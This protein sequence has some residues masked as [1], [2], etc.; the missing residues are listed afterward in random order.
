MSQLTALAAESPA[1]ETGPEGRR[2]TRHTCDITAEY[3]VLG[4]QPPRPR[5]GCL[6]NLSTTGLALIVG[7]P[8]KRR[9]RLGV[10]VQSPDYQFSY[11]LV[12]QV[13]RTLPYHD[14]WLLGC[15]FDRPLSNN[16]LDNLL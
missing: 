6:I 7:H 12:G 16:E 5:A 4:D 3:Y 1:L 11:L 15:S 2:A 14:A 10:E 13:V 9:T 8:L